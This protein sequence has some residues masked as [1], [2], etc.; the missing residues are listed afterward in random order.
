MKSAVKPI[1]LV[2]LSLFFFNFPQA[3]TVSFEALN[4]EIGTL[5]TKLVPDKRVA[6]LTAELIDTLQKT[7]VL[8]GK[9]DLPEAKQQLIQLLAGK[10]IPFIDSLILLPDAS[11]GEKY[12]ALASL[13]VSTMRAE[14]DDA[15]ELVT[16]VMMG[17][18]LK[19]LEQHKS[20]FKVQAPEGYLGWLDGTGLQRLSAG[21]MKLWKQSRRFIYNEITGFVYDAPTKDAAVVSDLVLG[22]LFE[23][24]SSRRGYLQ[25]KLP[26]GRQGFVSKSSCRSYSDWAES[27]PDVENMLAFA[28]QMMGSPYLWG[29]SSVK[30]LDCSGFTKVLYYSQAIILARDASQQARY[31]QVLDH[32]KTDDLQRGDLL[33]FGKSASRITHTGVYLG[34]GD[35]IHA[36]GRVLVSS[37]DPNDDKYLPSR[38]Y[39]AARRIVTALGNEGIIQVK[40]HPW[41]NNIR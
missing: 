32:Q 3:Q 10:G 17:T 20:W 30:A 40:N 28:F 31:G 37:I 7:P 33:F 18:P 4:K 19:I 1:V 29:G 36:S 11:I 5:K 14:P 15:S 2:I 12:W 13:S 22:D 35:F 16:Q 25:I 6:I 41:Y 27:A 9:T 8:K 24:S 34:K 21:E 38:N 23:A 26:D 39:V